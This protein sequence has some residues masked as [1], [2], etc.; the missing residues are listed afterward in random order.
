M[1]LLFPQSFPEMYVAADLSVAK[2]E[3]P[4]CPRNPTLPADV[5]DDDDEEE[6]IR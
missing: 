1:S 2:S 6:G 4:P 3:L 5:N